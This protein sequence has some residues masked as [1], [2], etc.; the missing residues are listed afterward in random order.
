MPK[1]TFRL[2]PSYTRA[3][4]PSNHNGDEARPFLTEQQWHLLLINVHVRV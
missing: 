4:G 2:P 1:R 3:Y